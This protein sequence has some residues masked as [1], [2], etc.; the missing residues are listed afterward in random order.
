MLDLTIYKS[1]YY[2]I[3]LDENVVVNIE[4]PKRKQLKKILSLTK[5][6]KNNNLTEEDIDSL[7]EAAEI[8]ISKNKEGRKFTAEQI[9]EYLPLDA[10]IAFFDG[11]Y[12]WVTEN[13]GQK[14]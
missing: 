11:Y 13:I 4:P 5:S 8:A 12:N 7:Y 3:K 9:E 6:V 10:I 1:R 14:N 2:D